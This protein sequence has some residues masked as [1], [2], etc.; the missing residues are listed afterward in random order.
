MKNKKNITNKSLKSL[1]PAGIS[2][3]GRKV[4]FFGIAVLIAGFIVLTKTDPAG[5]NMA[6]M[7]SPFLILGGYLIIGIGI[8]VPNRTDAVN[9]INARIN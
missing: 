6:S 8:F 9:D 3:L 1:A 7:I 5:Q 2:K 4:I